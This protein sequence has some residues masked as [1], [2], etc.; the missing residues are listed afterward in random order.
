MGVPAQRV[1]WDAVGYI[2][3]L[4]LLSLSL[5]LRSAANRIL[6]GQATRSGGLCNGRRG[7]ARGRA[8]APPES[9]IGGGTV[10]DTRQRTSQCSRVARMRWRGMRTPQGA[11]TAHAARYPESSRP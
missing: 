7:A 2:S 8:M 4:S 6:C 5:S 9:E 1:A 11:A 3:Y 10:W